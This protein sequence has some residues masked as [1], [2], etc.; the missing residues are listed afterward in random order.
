MTR[1]LF[2]HP[3]NVRKNS[4]LWWVWDL[5]GPRSL[6]VLS[7]IPL[8][9]WCVATTASE[10]TFFRHGACM[11]SPPTTM[12]NISVPLAFLVFFQAVHLHLENTGSPHRKKTAGDNDQM[13]LAF[14]KSCDGPC[15]LHAFKPSSLPQSYCRCHPG[16]ALLFQRTRCT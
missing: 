9:S 14:V 2:P 12:S 5:S 11:P 15:I 8:S 4:K 6:Y 16:R 3:D 1:S 13:F 7:N 10:P